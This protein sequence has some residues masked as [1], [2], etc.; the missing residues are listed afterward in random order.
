VFDMCFK[1][2]Y[3]IFQRFYR[4]DGKFWDRLIAE[5]FNRESAKDIAG[6]LTKNGI[7]SDGRVDYEGIVSG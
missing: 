2:K 3:R 7:S 4:Y 5:T 6:Q 1:K